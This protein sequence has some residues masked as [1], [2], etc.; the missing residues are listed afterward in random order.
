MVEEEHVRNYLEHLQ[1]VELK[2]LKRKEEMRKNKEAESQLSYNDYDWD[3]MYRKGT[4]EK[5]QSKCWIS[6]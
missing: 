3:D 5:K 4:L 6:F 2:K 1:Y